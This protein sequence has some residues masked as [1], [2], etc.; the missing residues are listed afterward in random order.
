MD[1]ETRGRIQ[2][3][4]QDARRLLEDE[5]SAQL[6]GI[7]DVLP[8]GE[9]K[10][11][12][13]A[14]LDDG[15]RFVRQKIVAAI[16]HYRQMQMT[17]REAVAH[18]T[19]SAA[20][21]VLNRFVA[22]KMLEAR[23]LVTEC[24]SMGAESRG[25][26]EFTSLSPALSSMGD[27]AYRL[28]LQCIFDELS[29]EVRVLFDRTDVHSLLWPRRQAL[30]DLVAILNREALHSVW[31][32][33]ETIGWVYQYF[34]SSEE[35]REM[36]E[37]QAPRNTYEL[38]VRNQFFTPRFV[39]EFLVDNTLARIWHEMMG[40]VSQVGLRRAYFV[41]RAGETL[42]PRAKKDPRDVRLL[43]PACGSGHFLLYAFDVFEE[44]YEEAWNDPHPAVWAES[45]RSLRQDYPTTQQLH[46]AVPELILRHNLHGIDI[47]ARCAQIAGLALWMR[48]QRAFKEAAAPRDARPQIR[49][50]NIVVAEP[51]PGE[52]DLIDAFCDGLEPRLL[53]QLVRRTFDEMRTAGELGSLLAIEQRLRE[54]IDEARR[55]WAAPHRPLRQTNL[56]GEPPRPRQEE[57]LELA[58]VN[59]DFWETVEDAVIGALARFIAGGGGILSGVAS[60]PRTPPRDLH[61][62]KC[63]DGPS[64]LS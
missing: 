4:T 41:V 46:M 17:S 35:R 28:Y 60:L 9:V 61:T 18:F 5:F 34:N 3:A 53:G 39:V 64:T 44:I 43:D 56:F 58:G 26:R 31:P 38:A 47:D 42:A 51:M 14:H 21:T 57:L 37:A 15:Q 25:F 16:D 10:P 40:G 33:D 13:G 59:V 36:R 19:R 27:D 55:Q 22:L 50:T 63:R 29:L 2:T 11:L 54:T 32:T 6:E 1:R 24:V 52:Q 48:A 49:R 12:A 62:S 7:F 20:F 30:L 45:G 8:S 23:E